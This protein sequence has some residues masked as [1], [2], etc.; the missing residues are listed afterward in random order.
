MIADDGENVHDDQQ[1]QDGRRHPLGYRFEEG[2]H[3]NLKSADVV[4]NAKD[5]DYPQRADDAQSRVRVLNSC[6]DDRRNYR[7]PQ[8]D[9]VEP[10]PLQAPISNRLSVYLPR[11][12][13]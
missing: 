4:E 5:A 9:E 1:Q 2:Q 12:L 11:Q 13:L 8:N 10:V 6:L 7:H 3:E